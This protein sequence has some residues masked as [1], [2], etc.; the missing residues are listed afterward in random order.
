MADDEKKPKRLLED[1]IRKRD[2]L[3]TFIKIYQEMLE[4][5]DAKLSDNAGTSTRNNEVPAPDGADPLSVVYPGMFFGR[6]QPQ[7]VKLFLERMKPRPQRIKTILEALEKGGLKVGGKN[8][9][10]NIWKALKQNEDTFVNVP[11]AGWGLTEWYDPSSLAKMRRG[12]ESPD[13]N[14]QKGEAK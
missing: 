9:A 3:N 5:P 2:E 8:P 6:S 10:P 14:G 13:E 11:K 1:A 7:A 12:Q 4:L